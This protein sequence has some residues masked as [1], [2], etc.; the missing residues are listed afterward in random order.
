M[1]VPIIARPQRFY[2]EFL[3]VCTLACTRAL[4]VIPMRMVLIGLDDVSWPRTKSGA[5]GIAWR[6]VP[7]PDHDNRSLDQ[8][9]S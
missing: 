8:Y 2:R 3:P 4:W 7:P 6:D 9:I 1:S 5:I